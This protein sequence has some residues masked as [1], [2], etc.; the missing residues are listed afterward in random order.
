[1]V[2][3]GFDGVPLQ[4]LWVWEAGLDLFV[5]VLHRVGVDVN[6]EGNNL[7][8]DGPILGQDQSKK[9]QLSMRMVSGDSIIA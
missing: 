6:T 3:C 2:E 8:V 9:R 7:G 4:V 5:V 1:M